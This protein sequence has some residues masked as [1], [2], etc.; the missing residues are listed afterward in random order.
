MKTCK[1]CGETKP[2]ENYKIEQGRVVANCMPCQ[3]A[4]KRKWH[5]N[6]NLPIKKFLF[7]FLSSSKCKDCGESDLMVLEFDH[8]EDKSFNL[9][10]SHMIKGLTLEQLAKEVSKCE[11][12]CSNCHT[13]KTHEEQRTWRWEMGEAL[14]KED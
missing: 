13:R 8:T 9:G 3:T 4:Y 7:E 6:R 10:K 2:L 12:R 11:I 14:T 1:A 5:Y